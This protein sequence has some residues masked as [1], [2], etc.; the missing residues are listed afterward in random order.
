MKKSKGRV[1][2][3]VECGAYLALH[4]LARD[5]KCIFCALGVDNYSKRK[6][7]EKKKEITHHDNMKIKNNTRP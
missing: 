5:Q 1:F 2:Y 7:I 3:C 6:E 4:G